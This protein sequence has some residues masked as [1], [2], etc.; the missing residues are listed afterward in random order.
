MIRIKSAGINDIISHSDKEQPIEACGVLA[1]RIIKV[2]GKVVKEVLKLYKCKNELNS[3]TEYRINAEEQFQVFD[4][5]DRSGLD[6]LG[7]YHSHPCTNSR[8]SSIDKERGNY[9]GYS[10]LIVSLHPTKASSWIL[11]EDGFKEEEINI[12]SD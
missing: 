11:E 4:D 10:Y 1:G 8:P 9:F 7:F 2:N 6:L 12:I 5:I 3:P